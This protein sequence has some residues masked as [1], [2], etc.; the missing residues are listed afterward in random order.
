LN[1]KNVIHVPL[2][3]EK[4]KKCNLN[5]KKHNSCTFKIGDKLYFKDCKS[6]RKIHNRKFIYILN[7]TTK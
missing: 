3:L 4:I 5:G 7:L 2:K 1:G 6:L